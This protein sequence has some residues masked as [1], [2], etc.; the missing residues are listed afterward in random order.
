MNVTKLQYRVKKEFGS[1][2]YSFLRRKIQEEG[3]FDYEVA[4]ILKVNAASI[5]ELRRAMGLSNQ[6][7]FIRRFEQNYGPDAVKVF[8]KIVDDPFKTL[9]DAAR[10]FGF[11][12]EYARHVYKKLYGQPYSEE[13]K[14]KMLLRKLKKIEEKNMSSSRRRALMSVRERMRLLGLETGITN[15]GRAAVIV[16]DGKKVCL[17]ISS[18]PVKIN[19]K[20]YFHFNNMGCTCIDCDFY[21]C[22][23]QD[24]KE[25]AHYIIP[26]DEMPKA[27]LSI[28]HPPVTD[29]TKYAKFREAWH[30]FK[31]GTESGD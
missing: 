29:R 25:E 2:L 31:T 10:H 1:D 9:S 13:H 12:R 7:K 23:C 6:R 15:C 21:I 4:S 26:S 17:K 3:L 24:E 27:T 22:I 14:K 11:S 5:G 18:S 19:G 16:L 30:L 28:L 8:K 20:K